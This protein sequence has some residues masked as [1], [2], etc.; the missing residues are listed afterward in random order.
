MDV[1]LR[2]QRIEDLQVL[3]GEEAEFNDFGPTAIRASPVLPHLDEAGALTV[4]LADN[5]VA[6]SVSWHW[7]HWG[8]NRPS[9]CPMIGIWI[10][11]KYRG[12]GI[13]S[14]A[15]RQLAML[16]FSQTTTNRVEAHTDVENVAEQRALEAAGFLC[17]GIIRG[18]QWRNGAFH[19]GY[20]Y[21]ALRSDPVETSGGAPRPLP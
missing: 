1:S 19:D 13:G 3:T 2:A 12:Q 10:R 20:L 11:P 4:V 5:A 21:S 9:W 15:Q 18:A 17:E 14:V 16:F 8:P 6:G 7:R